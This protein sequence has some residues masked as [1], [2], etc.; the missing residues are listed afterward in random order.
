M[1]DYVPAWIEIGGPLPRKL[2]Q[3]LIDCIQGH[4]LSDDFGGGP[5]KAASA[6]DL[7]ELAQ[8]TEGQVGTLKLYD[9]R[10]HNGEFD[11]SSAA[12]AEMAGLAIVAADHPVAAARGN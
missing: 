10:A 3:G 2:V 11:G 9:E 4:G 5:I 7:L 8:D 12:V 1:A 6:D